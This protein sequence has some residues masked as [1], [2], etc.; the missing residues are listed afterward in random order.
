MIKPSEQLKSYALTFGSMQN[1]AKKA[2]IDT[3][4][5]FRL[6]KGERSAGGITIARIHNNTDFK[7]RFHEAWVIVEET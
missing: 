5:W 7:D 3:A 2:G 6:I 4:A 1:F